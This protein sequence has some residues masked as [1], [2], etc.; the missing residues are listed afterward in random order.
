[1]GFSVIPARPRRMN[2]SR[3]PVFLGRYEFPGPRFLSA[4]GGFTG[5]TTFY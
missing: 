4:S 2:S 3:N 5:V 1:M